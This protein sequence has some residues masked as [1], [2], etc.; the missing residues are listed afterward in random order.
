MPILKP[1]AEPS[2][3]AGK[4]CQ[5]YPD[6]R[7]GGGEPEVDCDGLGDGELL[8]VG[9][10]DGL[11]L[12]LVLDDGPELGSPDGPELGC[13]LPGDWPCDDVVG[14]E[15]P[16]AGEVPERCWPPPTDP[17]APGPAE[18]PPAPVMLGVVAPWKACGVCVCE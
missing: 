6:G 3:A 9:L 1:A 7:I 10:G 13:P 11:V 16:A 14:A 5:T 4:R 17:L 8:G 2:T 18:P 12:A 15:P